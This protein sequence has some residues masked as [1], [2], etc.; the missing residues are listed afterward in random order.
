[1]LIL[2]DNREKQGWDFTFYGFEQKGATLT[3]GDYQIANNNYFIFERKKS[4]GE[5]AINLGTKWRQFEAEM[6]RMSE[7][8]CP[9]IIC[10]FPISHMDTFP[11]NSG[12][13]EKEWP[14]LRMHPNFLKSRLYKSCEK[15]GIQLLFFNS[16][17]EALSEVVNII[18]EKFFKR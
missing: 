9:Y 16:S 14:Y 10:E 12:I 11:V 13:P 17:E 6:I 3:T 8:T 4:T 2:K 7:Y 1:M 15:Y 18:N 5:L